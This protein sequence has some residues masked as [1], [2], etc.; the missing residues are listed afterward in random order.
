M[1][2]NKL[3]FTLMNNPVRA[4]FQERVE[5]PV[6][7]KLASK[8]YY[9][10][11]LEIGCG[12][13]NGIRLIRKYFHPIK[14]VGVDLDPRMIDIARRRNRH[15]GL[16]FEVMDAACL[17]FPDDSFDAVFDFGIIH[18]IPN[19]RD[20]IREIKRVLKDSGE[21]ILED[22]AIES[23][24][25]FPAILGKKLMAHPYEFMYTFPEFERHLEETGF[26]I[27]KKKY[28]NLLKLLKYVSMS[29]KVNK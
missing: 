25:G 29:A 14:I 17:E 18:H 5:I 3:E 2:L 12:N 28:S 16:E 21:F 20:C 4:F 10:T 11:A 15:N 7:R 22:L 9:P 1:I 19:W 6:L 27:A 13:G 24:S 23:F 8:S 26:F